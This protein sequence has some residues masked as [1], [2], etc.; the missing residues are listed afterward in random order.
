MKAAVL[1][2]PK[3]PLEMTELTIDE[4]R[5]GEALVRV[6]VAGVCHSDL[7]FIEGTYPGQYPMVLGHE[8]A[9]IVEELGP[10]VTNVA[11]GD[12]VIMGFVLIF[13]H[14]HSATEP[15][16]G[17]NGQVSGD[18]LANTRRNELKETELKE[19]E[20]AL[21]A[22][23]KKASKEVATKI[24]ESEKAKAAATE[25]Q[26]AAGAAQAASEL[27]KKEFEAAKAALAASTPTCDGAGGDTEGLNLLRQELQ[28]AK[29]E[30]EA[31]NK[32]AAKATSEAEQAKAEAAAAAEK[33]PVVK[34]P[35][36]PE[37]L[38]PVRL[39]GPIPCLPCA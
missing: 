26:E 18:V 27:A 4:P 9:G 25:A 1:N 20:L 28:R 38:A 21:E 2:G 24:E 35:V 19:K 32:N 29:G 3:T 5:A 34:C 6:V 12:R 37:K 39:P 30:A 36:C 8:V 16:A 33:C 10:G 14:D 23:S 22:N 13:L 11:K 7:H 15:P 31:A 17:D